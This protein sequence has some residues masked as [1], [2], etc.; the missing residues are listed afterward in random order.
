MKEVHFSAF[1]SWQKFD[2]NTCEATASLRLG[3]NIVSPYFPDDMFDSNSFSFHFIAIFEIE[4]PFTLRSIFGTVPLF[5]FLDYL[6][7]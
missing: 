2:H 3:L 4:S 1:D 5:W 7:R 6:N